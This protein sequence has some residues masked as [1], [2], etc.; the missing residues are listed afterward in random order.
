MVIG[1]ALVFYLVAGPYVYFRRDHVATDFG[2]DDRI[3]GVFRILLFVAIV[4]IIGAYY[5]EVRHFLVVDLVT[6]KI[7]FKSAVPYRLQYSYGLPNFIYYRLGFLVLPA[8]VAAYTVI[9]CKLRGCFGPLDIAVIILCFVPQLLLG[10]K[11]GVLQVGIVI[12]I[13]LAVVSGLRREPLYKLISP[14]MVGIVFLLLLPIVVILVIY[15]ASHETLN[16]LDAPLSD[17][18]HDDTKVVYDDQSRETRQKLVEA[19]FKRNLSPER[20]IG[21][22]WP[23]IAKIGNRVFVIHSEVLALSVPFTEE[24]GKLGGATLPRA[25]GLLPG[26]QLII[27]VPMHI[28]AMDPKSAHQVFSDYDFRSA[29]TYEWFSGSMPVPALAEGYI[30]FGWAGFLIFGIVTV[31]SVILIQEILWRLRLGL[32]PLALMAWYGYLAVT[33][34]MYSVFA[35]FISLIHTGV[36]LVL[37]GAYWAITAITHHAMKPKFDKTPI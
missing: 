16:V 14:R 5:L 32:L 27:E 6:G 25:R 28:Y 9:R 26:K 4:T 30:N 17:L 23:M 20:L 22:L 12:L 13:A 19:R 24:Y 29:P 36:L 7:N 15:E 33:L 8:I 34:S 35:T 37:A 3:S 10:E 11:S 31:A 21:N 2:D 18:E 1:E